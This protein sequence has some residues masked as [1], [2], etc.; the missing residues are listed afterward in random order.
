MYI[1]HSYDIYFYMHMYSTYIAPHHMYISIYMYL[2]FA[3]LHKKSCHGSSHS[4]TKI[5]KIYITY[6]LNCVCIAQVKLNTYSQHL[7]PSSFLQWTLNLLIHFQSKKPH[8]AYI[9]SCNCCEIIV[10]SFV[11]DNGVGN[12]M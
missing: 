12:R 5:T 1:A 9:L 6:L 11:T 10:M 8:I 4:T 7:C 2:A 3:N